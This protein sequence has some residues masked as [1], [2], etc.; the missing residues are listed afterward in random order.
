MVLVRKLTSPNSLI[1]TSSILAHA[2]LQHSARRVYTFRFVTCVLQQQRDDTVLWHIVGRET[3]DSRAVV[4]V[5]PEI[6][7]ASGCLMSL[8]VD[9]KR[10]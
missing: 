10:C 5:R 7:S 8:C 2:P 1:N 4:C 6:L 9:G 3:A